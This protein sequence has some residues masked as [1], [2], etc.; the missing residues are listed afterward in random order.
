[1]TYNETEKCWNATINTG[2]FTYFGITAVNEFG[3]SELRQIIYI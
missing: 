1:M 2:S 3:E